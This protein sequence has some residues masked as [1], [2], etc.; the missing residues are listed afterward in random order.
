MSAVEDSYY[1]E[2]AAASYNGALYSHYQ[3]AFGVAA[4]QNTDLAF[5]GQTTG[6]SGIHKVILEIAAVA[7]VALVVLWAIQK[8][9]RGGRRK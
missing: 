9:W 5:A 7:V 6:N 4:P 2:L 3:D 8:R 1:A